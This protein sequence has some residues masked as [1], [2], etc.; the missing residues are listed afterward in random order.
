KGITTVKIDSIKD[1]YT[2]GKGRVRMDELRSTFV[3]TYLE[4]NKTKVDFW[5]SSKPGGDLPATLF[6]TVLRVHPYVTLAGL[7]KMGQMEK[8]I[9]KGKTSKYRES[10]EITFKT[11]GK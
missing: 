6:N 1:P 10:A 5:L 11:K 7:R 4:R 8:Y 2:E 3:L 9:A